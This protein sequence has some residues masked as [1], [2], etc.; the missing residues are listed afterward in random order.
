MLDLTLLGPA[1][2]DHRGLDGERRV[3]GDFK[4]GGSGGQHGNT[5]HLAQF[6]GGF[7]INGVENV[8]ESDAVG[9]VLGDEFLQADRNARQ[10][11]GHRVARGNFDGAADDAHEAIIVA[12]IGEQIDYPVSGIFRAAVDAEDAHGGSVAGQ[13]S[14]FR[15]QLSALSIQILSSRP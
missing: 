10:A 14:V 1:V 15:H 5:A 11:R 7:H 4:P 2:S 9:P 13:Q 6:Q 12:A 3:F 8:F